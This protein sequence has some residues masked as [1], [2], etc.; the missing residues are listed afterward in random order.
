MALIKS[1]SG[2]RGTIGG[3]TGAGLSGIDIVK[4]ASAY[5]EFIRRGHPRSNVIV[6]GRDAR[7]SGPMVE[8]LVVGALTSMGFDVVNIGLA[9]TPTTEIAVTMEKAAGGIIIT[10]SHNP[11]Q[12]NAL[13]LLNSDGEF[14]NDCEGKKV[15]E[16]A[17]KEDITF[18]DIDHIGRVFTNN[19]YNRR[20]IEAVMELPLVDCD[21]IKRAGFRVAVDAVNSVGGVVIPELLRRL[22]VKEV[23]ELNCEPNGRFAH[24]PEPIPENLTQI[25]DLMKSGCADVG[26][27]V[28]PDVD[29]LAIVMENGEMFVEEYTLVAVADYVLSHTPGN[30]V[31]NLSSSRALRDVTHKHGCDYKASAVGE[32]NVVKAMKDIGA[33]IGGE[34]NGGVIYP[35]LH[36]GRDALVGV[37]LFLTLLA[38]SGKKVTELKKTYPQYAISKNKIELTPEIDVDAILEAMKEKYKNENVTDIDG[39]KIDF[40]D[41]WVHLRKSNTE[42]II[43]IYAEASTTEA[44]ERLG[45]DIKKIVAEVAGIK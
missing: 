11:A 43:R 23:I 27:V 8:M 39:V 22:G 2:I 13:K 9:T 45:E 3:K 1:I 5:G 36:Y 40:E 32:V 30:T 26:F 7:L 29:R 10:A 25:S 6:V 28:D 17:D 21:A 12:W 35:E 41:C 16:I 4:F 14:L 24:T 31:S 34:G 37:A 15:L 44:A 42:P 38:K 20:H 19:T 18:A 33:V